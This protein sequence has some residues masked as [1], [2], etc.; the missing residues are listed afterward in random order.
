MRW[1]TL[2]PYCCSVR[3]PLHQQH[4]L[5]QAVGRVGLLGIAVPEVVLLERHRREL[6][7][8]AD[9]AD[10]DELLHAGQPRA[11]HEVDAH[12]GVVVEE[13]AWMLAIGA[14]AA[15]HRGQVD[16]HVRSPVRERLPYPRN[17]P[18]V[19]LCAARDED[20]G[21]PGRPEPLDHRPSQEAGAAGHHDPATLQRTAHQR[22]LAAAAMPSTSASHRSASS[23]MRTSSVKVVCG[24]Q[25][26]T[27][28]AL[29]ASPSSSSTSVGR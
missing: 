27:R 8:G 3:L 28:S 29:E 24:R 12:D 17:G 1:M 14:D 16:D 21:H 6:R 18:Q 2:K 25:P 5:G 20:I 9:R 10:G 11:L 19:V 7:I 4:L 23:M 13:G 15:H 22:A 26:S